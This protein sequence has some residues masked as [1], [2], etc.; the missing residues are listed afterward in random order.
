VPTFCRHNRL[1]ATCPVCSRK[2]KAVGKPAGPVPRRPRAASTTPAPARRRAAGADVRVRRLAGF[3]ADD[4]FGSEL[5]PGL[6]SSDDAARLAAEA[7]F[8]AARLEQLEAEPPEPLAAAALGEDREAAAE[9]CALVALL[10]PLE[11]AAD[12]FASVLAARD[13]AP[14]AE[15]PRGPLAVDD[16]AATF[17]AFRRWAGGSAVAALR[18]DAS[19]PAARRFERAFERLALPGLHRAARYELLVLAGRLGVVDARPWTLELAAAAPDDPVLVSAKRVFGIG[20]LALVTRRAR[21][22]CEAGGVPMAALDLG[23]RNFASPGAR[24]RRGVTPDEG[25]VAAAEA[26][27]RDALGL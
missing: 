18:G 14:L 11:E 27:L 13:G 25:L 26:R 23:L 2:A 3:G 21:A 6:R 5:V 1:E 20:D 17:A 22:L 24:L 10:A 19:W 8:A 4:G 15:L 9:L 12:P 7:A 16:P